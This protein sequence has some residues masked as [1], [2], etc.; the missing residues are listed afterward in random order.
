MQCV[1][2]VSVMCE[3]TTSI[4]KFTLLNREQWLTLSHSHHSIGMC[5]LEGH[6]RQVG[7][8]KTQ[9]ITNR[10]WVTSEDALCYDMCLHSPWPESIPFQ[11]VACIHGNMLVQ[12]KLTLLQ[13]AAYDG[14]H[15]AASLLLD[16][17]ARV[18]TMNE[19]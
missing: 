17:G 9:P 4:K 11:L 16:R 15:H 6:M 18:D 8:K 2:C 1:L 7:S 13:R 19:V 14:N 5:A 3:I 12:A 10:S